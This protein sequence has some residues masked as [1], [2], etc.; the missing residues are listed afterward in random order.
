VLHPV[1][2]QSIGRSR[3][4]LG[5]S[6]RARHRQD[7]DGCN[8]S[9]ENEPGTDCEHPRKHD[10]RIRVGHPAKDRMFVEQSLESSDIRAHRED[11]QQ[12]PERNGEPAPRP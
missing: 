7:I 3:R 2:A 1:S 12:E 11:Q 10:V 8:G 6:Q 4:P 5:T 9:T